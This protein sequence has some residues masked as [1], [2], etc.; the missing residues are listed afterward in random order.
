MHF[1]KAMIFL[2]IFN[3]GTSYGAGKN[4]II[5]ESLLGF[6][7]DSKQYAYSKID[8]V[9]DMKPGL[10]SVLYGYGITKLELSICFSNV[11]DNSVAEDCVI[12]KDL[13]PAV[14]KFFGTKKATVDKVIAQT[15][16]LLRD[17]FKK[18]Y[19]TW[20]EPVDSDLDNLASSMDCRNTYNDDEPC[21]VEF[22]LYQGKAPRKNL[23]TF[24]YRP[25]HSMYENPIDYARDIR[26]GFLAGST[27]D[28]KNTC[29]YFYLKDSSAMYF[30]ELTKVLCFSM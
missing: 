5:N 1:I 27:T 25:T 10:K 30:G 15:R 13:E 23:T 11:K 16:G 22:S 2:V 18:R 6:S 14:R 4:V 28:K 8:L 21:H 29:H 17:E 7:S 26:S 9:L 24:H 20:Q 19:S 3:F 12:L